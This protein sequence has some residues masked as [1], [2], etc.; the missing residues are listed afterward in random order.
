MVF[1]SCTSE[2]LPTAIPSPT[3]D[4]F[5]T[6]DWRPDVSFPT[7]VG[8]VLFSDEPNVA[9]GNWAS[10]EVTCANSPDGDSYVDVTIYTLG[11]KSDP[12]TINLQL[13]WDEGFTELDTWSESEV[14]KKYGT[15]SYSWDDSGL[16]VRG[17]SPQPSADYGNH[18]AFV[19]RLSQHNH[20]KIDLESAQGWRQVSFNL[21]GFLGAYQPVTREC[22]PESIPPNS[23]ASPTGWTRFNFSDDI[24]HRVD[25][26]SYSPSPQGA[27]LVTRDD[28][29]GE[30]YQFH[31]NCTNPG[32]TYVWSRI[33]LTVPNPDEDTLRSLSGGLRD[34]TLGVEIDEEVILGQDWNGRWSLR[35]YS[36]PGGRVTGNAAIVSLENREDSYSLLEEMYNRDAK[37]VVFTLSRERYNVRMPFDVRGFQE[38]LQPIWDHCEIS[39]GD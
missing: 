13:E 9:E 4:F 3:P 12:A 20:L 8:T 18:S 10:L 24:A 31:I 36:A 33:T 16:I 7:M 32:F 29:T 6:G 39:P 11:Y 21:A 37:E 15:E 17:L 28:I 22:F 27:Y 5:Y 30:V 1:M 34:L 19:D 14:W 23:P 38:A 2:S 25:R 26:P 35:S